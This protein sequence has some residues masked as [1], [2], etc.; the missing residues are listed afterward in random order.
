[1]FNKLKMLFSIPDANQYEA[2][3][4]NL[5]Q[6]LDSVKKERL[7][8]VLATLNKLYMPDHNDSQALND[9]H[10]KRDQIVKDFIT[11]NRFT[12]DYKALFLFV[13]QCGLPFYI[14]YCNDSKMFKTEEV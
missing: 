8:E 3:H 14:Y 7:N 9:L 2:A 12:V 4:S 11:C 6:L 13:P 5:T 1:M 10:N